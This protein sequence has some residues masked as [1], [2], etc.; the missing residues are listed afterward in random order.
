MAI[1]LRRDRKHFHAFGG[2]WI[3]FRV[4]LVIATGVE[5]AEADTGKIIGI[6]FSAK[7]AEHLLDAP[8]SKQT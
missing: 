2:I 7:T 8:H 3:V 4:A 5:N 1:D 6:I